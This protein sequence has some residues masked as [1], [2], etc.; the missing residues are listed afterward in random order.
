MERS[1]QA[2]A[3]VSA[4]RDRIA[5][6]R[7]RLA[8]SRDDVAADRDR[9]RRDHDALARRLERL[10]HEAAARRRAEQRDPTQVLSGR[11]SAVPERHEPTRS[12]SPAESR[13]AGVGDPAHRSW[14]D[15]AADPASA[16]RAWRAADRGERETDRAG[17]PA[18]DR[19][20][21]EPARPEPSGR[22][23]GGILRRSRPAA[24]PPQAPAPQPVAPARRGPVAR[25]G[26]MVR[27]LVGLV[28]LMIAF[29]VLGVVGVAAATDRS[30]AQ[31]VDR[32]TT[33]LDQ[34]RAVGGG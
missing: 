7:D 34:L 19:V 8:R 17:W 28:V 11:P 27:R 22:D 6:D 26:R 15:P 16:L 1:R 23:G 29:A 12:L 18:A 21:A 24:A 14:R 20:V 10:E 4:Q 9:L 32:V 5:A 30:P 31:V 25:L 3:A 33:V 13:G 2:T